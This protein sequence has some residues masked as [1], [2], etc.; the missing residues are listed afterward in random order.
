MT[1]TLNVPI[2]TREHHTDDKFHHEIIHEI[3]GWCMVQVWNRHGKNVPLPGAATAIHQ[4]PYFGGMPDAVCFGTIRV[5]QV[6]RD[7]YPLQVVII[8]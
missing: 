1:Q 3:K 4:I 2:L 6:S 7:Y 8:G 5:P